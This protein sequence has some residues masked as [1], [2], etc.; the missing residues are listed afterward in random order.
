MARG[1]AFPSWRYGPGGASKVFEEGEKIPDGWEDHPDKVKEPKPRA[2]AKSTGGKGGKD[3][4][5]DAKK[6]APARSET[7]GTEEEQ[8][9]RA[10][11]I[12]YLKAANID[13][14][15]NASTEE[16]EAIMNADPES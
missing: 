2:A 15:E 12:E 4:A 14:D 5:K 6:T 1:K 3:A 8:R 9:Y 13:F 7:G 16:L 11:V 10:E